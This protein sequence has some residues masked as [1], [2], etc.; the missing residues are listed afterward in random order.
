MVPGLTDLTENSKKRKHKISTRYGGQQVRGVYKDLFILGNKQ[1][2]E[3][4]SPEGTRGGHNPP[5]RAWLLASQ[6]RPGVL[7]PPGSLSW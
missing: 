2:E 7:C 4:Q 3:K 5:G 1:T 6:A